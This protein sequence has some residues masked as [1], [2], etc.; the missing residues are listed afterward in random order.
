MARSNTRENNQGSVGKT[1]GWKQRSNF[2]VVLR[3][4]QE[5]VYQLK[6]GL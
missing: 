1:V 3:F 4:L 6:D 2:L 5:E